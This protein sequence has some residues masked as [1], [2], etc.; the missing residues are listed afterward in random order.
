MLEPLVSTRL[1]LADWKE[2][3]AQFRDK[4]GIKIS[5][6]GAENLP[7]PFWVLADK[8]YIGQVMVNLIINSIRYGKEGGQTRIRFRDMLD[9]IL[10]EVEDNGSGIAKED[11]PRVF[12]RFY[13]TDKGR[14]REQGGTGLGLSIVKNA[15]LIHGGTISVRNGER[16]GLEFTFTLR[17]HS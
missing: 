17:K 7:S 5:V 1:P 4:K 12:E 11:L 16:G 13:R 2:G 3:F 10:I 9:K 8:H 14:S 15:V 6:K